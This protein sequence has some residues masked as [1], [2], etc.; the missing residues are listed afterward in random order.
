MKLRDLI[1]RRSKLA[2][3]MRTLNDT[4]AGDNGDLSE[5]QESR[6]GE[7]RT[8]LEA[9]E[10]RI[11]RQ[12]A[13]DAAERRV[14]GAPADAGTNRFAAEVRSRFSVARA[15]AGAAGLGVDDGF[16]RE[17]AQELARR[18]NRSFEGV[19]VPLEAL[20]PE[21]R[22]V[23]GTT[24]ADLIG[25]DHSAE[26]IDRLRAGT[27]A[28][29]L[30]V[31]F[32]GGLRGDLDV[33]KLASSSVGAWF[34]D[35]D[36][37]GESDPG[38]SKVSMSPKHLGART[39]F[40]RT[41][42]LQSVPAVEGIIRGDLASV[43]SEALD[44]A[45]FVGTG[46]GNEPTGIHNQAGVGSM[47]TA[48]SL[49]IAQAD[50]IEL[51]GALAEANADATGFAMSPTVAK[52]LRKLE[53]GNGKLLGLIS[54]VGRSATMEGLPVATSTYLPGVA[55]GDKAITAGKWSDVMVGMWG[56]LDLM[57]NP[58]GDAYFAKGAVG[59]R[60]IMAADIAVRH[61]ESFATLAVKA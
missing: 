21:R 13:I 3:E 14:A 24:G 47:E 61:P 17:A 54:G 36:T 23:D 57:V 16:E 8:E 10:K 42:L 37:I 33:P 46:V 15:I 53:D 49:A 12:T 4:P 50:V 22:T 38:F 1:E 58:Y 34:A 2:Q 60:A 55:A 32:I 51:L 31:R 25:T 44:K 59:V 6:F 52:A 9:L 26:I 30:G 48:A 18:E 28:N 40:S 43:L 7:L 45:I 20:A 39:A 19:A 41:M 11:E 35:G 5:A 56:S 27:A 29:R